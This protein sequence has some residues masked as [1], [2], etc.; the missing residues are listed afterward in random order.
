ML[1]SLEIINYF[2][3]NEPDFF[4]N[5]NFILQNWN[6]WLEEILKIDGFYILFNLLNHFIKN[7]KIIKELINDINT[8]QI[9]NITIIK[10]I[11]SELLKN[12]IYLGLKI[13]KDLIKI[14]NNEEKYNAYK[15][16][17]DILFKIEEKDFN[18]CNM[19]SIFKTHIDEYEKEIN[20]NNLIKQAYYA[21]KINRFI[22]YYYD[23]KYRLSKFRYNLEKNKYLKLIKEKEN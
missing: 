22:K 19:L 5:D 9:I 14:E 23:D 12:L 17:F 16:C 1:I 20:N 18:I 7:K 2:K 4:L 21:Q 11:D 13:N 15:K 3:I 10:I 8:Y 6:N